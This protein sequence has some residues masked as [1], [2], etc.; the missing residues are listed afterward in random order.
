MPSTV[1]ALPILRI[2]PMLR[3]L[4]LLNRLRMLRKLATQATLRE[5]RGLDML[6][7]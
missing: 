4:P 5:E 1:P 7:G 2:L 6:C 3:I